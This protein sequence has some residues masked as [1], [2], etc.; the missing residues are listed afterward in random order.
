MTLLHTDNLFGVQPTIMS[1][2]CFIW[3]Y[4]GSHDCSKVATAPMVSNIADSV[5]K[6]RFIEEPSSALQ[7]VICL[8]VAEGPRQHETCG[9]L[10]CKECL[11]KY[12]RDKPCPNCRREQPLYFEDNRG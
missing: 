11:E 7:C 3:L 9:R 10:F 4:A 5:S 8:D 1:M 12:G 6:Y 2:V